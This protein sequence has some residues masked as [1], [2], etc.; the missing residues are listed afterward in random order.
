MKSRYDSVAKEYDEI[1]PGYPDILI[2]RLV[3]EAN[4]EKDSYLLEIGAGTGKATAA[5]AKMGFRIDCIEPEPNMA[6]IMAE[7]CAGL[8]NVSAIINDFETWEPDMDRAYDLV[9]SAQAF[10]WIDD[11]IKYEKCRRILKDTGKIGLFWYFS[12]MEPED[13]LE[14]LNPIFR[15]FGTGYACG[16]IEDFR[17]FLVKEKSKLQGSGCFGE[18]N[19]YIFEGA[20]TKSDASKFVKRFNTTSAYAKLDE[21]AKRLINREL[22]EVIS[23]NGGSV[24]DK[25]V[26][27]LLTA[28]KPEK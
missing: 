21:Q 19:E 13:A 4:L 16:G 5:L 24:G 6:G 11:A 3:S 26:Y 12:I 9:F 7:K 18:I 2:E 10:H 23:L 20:T 27:F 25:L 14:Y 22:A 15:K 1:R 17:K 8:P 28:K